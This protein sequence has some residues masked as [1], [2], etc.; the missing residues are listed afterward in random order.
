MSRH[1]QHELDRLEKQLLTLSAHAEESIHNSIRAFEERDIELADKVIEYDQRIDAMEVD[2]EEDC[3]K[4]LALYQPV[5]IDLRFI[6]AAL[7]INNDLERVGDCATTIAKRTK[8]LAKYPPVTINF[9]FHHMADKALSLLRKSLDSFVN[10]DTQLAHE[11]RLLDKEVDNMN[12]DL[13]RLAGEAI[14][15]TPDKEMP[16]LQL[17]WVSR[18]LERVGDHAT[19][20]AEDIIYMLEGEIV[21]HTAKTVPAA[22]TGPAAQ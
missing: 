15:T 9:D 10:L 20:I 14:R 11:V 4:I 17:M 3:L 5:A 16:L 22:G 12:N 8:T 18:T 1:L 7:K 21:R 2:L 6:I 19:N 13:E